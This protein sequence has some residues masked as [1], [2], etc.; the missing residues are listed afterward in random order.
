MRG[1][2]AVPY[3]LWKFLHRQIRVKIYGIIILGL[4]LVTPGKR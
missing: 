2:E 3:L 4:K 1:C